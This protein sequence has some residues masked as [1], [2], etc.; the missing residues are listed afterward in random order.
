MVTEH[1]V[2]GRPRTKKEQIKKI[3]FKLYSYFVY[4]IANDETNI[5]TEIFNKQYL[6]HTF[7]L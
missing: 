6:N 5:N 2:F 1:A 7:L 4:E 3:Q